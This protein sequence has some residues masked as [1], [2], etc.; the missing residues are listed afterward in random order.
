VIR[1]TPTPTGGGGRPG[2]VPI[3]GKLVL[4]AVYLYDAFN[5][6]TASILVD[7]SVGETQFHTWDGWRQCSQHRLELNGQGTWVA[8]PTKQFVW[9]SRLDEMVAYRRSTATGWQN[10]FVLHGGQDTAAKLV[11][12]SGNVVEQYEYDPY[13]RVKVFAGSSTTPVAAS[14]VGLPFLWKAIR[15]DEITG[16]LQ[17]R[18]RYYSVELG[19]FLTRDPIG[20][21]GDQLSFGNEHCYAGGSPL[22]RGDVLGLQAGAAKVEFHYVNSSGVEIV[23]DGSDFGVLGADGV[24]SMVEK[25]TGQKDYE[26]KFDDYVRKNMP[27]PSEVLGTIAGG[28]AFDTAVGVA[29]GAVVS[30]GVPL[31]LRS[32]GQLAGAVCHH[33]V[34]NITGFSVK[35]R[36]IAQLG[37][38]LDYFLGHA[39]GSA[40]NIERSLSMARQLAGIGLVDCPATR[41]FL[42]QHLD[43]AIN[44]GGNIARVQENGYVVIESLLKGPGGMLKWETVWDGTKLITG[45]LYGG[46]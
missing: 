9:G 14:T 39:T 2:Y 43:D 31:L 11:D 22:V 38:K 30:K 40:H 4:A 23:V 6:R 25:S 42:A 32:V 36:L 1:I 12:S 15:L 46:R 29:T 35:L 24:R 33:A 8:T 10:Y 34:T 13:G 3:T 17:M 16:L 21:W 20:V 18:H 44:A 19:R 45:V 7:P 28:L 5:R 27:S 26:S 37:N 41:R